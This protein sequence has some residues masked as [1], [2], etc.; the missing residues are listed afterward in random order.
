MTRFGPRAITVDE[1]L[2]TIDRRIRHLLAHIP[3]TTAAY[4]PSGFAQWIHPPLTR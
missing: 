4:P 2:L 3:V 1:Y